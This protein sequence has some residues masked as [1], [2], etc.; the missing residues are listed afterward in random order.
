MNGIDYAGYQDELVRLRRY[1][2]MWPE[3]AMEERETAE[4]V[5]RYLEGLGLRPE[6]VPENGVTVMV[7]APEG[8]RECCKTV[9]VRAEMDALP[10][11]E[12]GDQ[13]WRSQK[14]GIMHACGHDAILASGLGLAKICTE[15]REI[16]PV[17]VKFIFQPAEENG[18]GTM[19][20]LDAG[21]MENPHVDDYVMFHYVNDGP[22]RMELHRGAASAA[23]GSVVL[24][25]KGKAA[26]WCSCE[27]G[28]DSIYAAAKVLDVIHE[29]NE[30]FEAEGP[31]VLGIGMMQGG[32]AKNIVAEETVLQGT[33]R[34]CDLGDY[35]KLR[36]M[37]LEGLS[38][39]EKETGTVILAEVD[40]E[41]IPP[42]VNDDEMVD[43]ALKVG[44]E[45]WGQDCRL[46]KQMFL[47]GDSAAYYFQYAR[48][49]FMVFNAGKD[50][51]KNYPL[52]S[53]RFDIREEVL[54]KSVAT[55]HRFLLCL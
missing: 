35:Q 33:L 53:S 15:Y 10:V 43:L 2:H 48:G 8:V 14:D 37:L 7:W 22:M 23:I 45:V 52:H 41:P 51:E 25:I 24:R 42:I 38:R 6:M 54:W 26:H 27:Q 20:M 44:A 1:F 55:L 40:E 21:I 31:F 5:F 32:K 18:Q 4:F 13:L 9:A 12:E 47:S 29:I 19:M 34:S 36:R 50:G 28:I 49:I 46:E 3:V 11:Q 17:N 39:V 16:L 30:T